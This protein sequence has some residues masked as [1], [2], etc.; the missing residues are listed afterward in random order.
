MKTVTSLPYNLFKKFVT[1][2]IFVYMNISFGYLIITNKFDE[3]IMMGIIVY[4]IVTAICIYF[5]KKSKIVK[6]DDLGMYINGKKYDWNMILWIKK[7]TFGRP[8]L[9][10]EINENGNYKT[11]KTLVS[12]FTIDDHEKNIN[13]HIKKNKNNK[14]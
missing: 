8:I 6:Y 9:K 3:T 7:P 13:E 11:I 1:V 12:P 5:L 14:N 4:L 10:I 2:L